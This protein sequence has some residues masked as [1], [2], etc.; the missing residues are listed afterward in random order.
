[1]IVGLCR[2]DKVLL[3]GGTALASSVALFGA[4]TLALGVPA[5]GFA[6]ILADGIFRPSSGTFYPTI[7]K[8]PRT[9]PQVAL[10]FDD[11]PDEE[12][13][14]RVLDML[15][16]HDARATFFMIGKH[17]ERAMSI[18]ARAVAEGHE[19]GNHSWAHAYLQNF[20]SVPALLADIERTE[21]LIQRLTTRSIVPLY[22]APVGL[23][24]PRLARAAHARA[25]DI[26]AWSV[27]SRDTIDPNPKSVAER[28]LS[29]IRPGDIVLMHDGHQNAGAQRRSGAESLPLVLQ[30]L[31]ARGLRPVTVSELIHGSVAGSPDSE[32]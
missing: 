10:T 26:V 29:K 17:L 24:S 18:G 4:S 5:V 20:Y 16:A 22:R 6:A 32:G 9:L 15:G 23:K 14:P 11:G 3:A 12:V 13:T 25:L 19:L 30:G 7:S 8:G 21:T 31:R 2:A 27:H 1:V 28:V